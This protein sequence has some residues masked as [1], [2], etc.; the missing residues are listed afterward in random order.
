M[1]ISESA[2]HP[3]MELHPTPLDE[4][5]IFRIMRSRNWTAGILGSLEL[6]RCLADLGGVPLILE[7]FVREVETEC[8]GVKEETS[9]LPYAMLRRRTVEYMVKRINPTFVEYAPDLKDLLFRVLCNRQPFF[10]QS[11]FGGVTVD[12]LQ[13]TGILSLGEDGLIRMPIVYLVSESAKPCLL[14]NF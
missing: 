12:S 13:R 10:L 1:A 8:P 6:K 2:R 3:I 14:S 5:D 4:A 11:S 9:D 7:A